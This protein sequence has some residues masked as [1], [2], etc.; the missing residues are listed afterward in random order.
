MDTQVL[1]VG[2]G[3]S[4]LVAARKLK[5]HGVSSLILDKGRSVGGRLATRRIQDGL[6][7]HGAQF[8]TA[9][10]QTFQDQIDKWI[11]EDLVYVWGHGWSDG[12]LK[13]TAGDGHPRYVTR[14]GMNAMAQRIARDLDGVHVNVQVRSVEYNEGLWV[15]TDTE[16]KVFTGMALL[17]TPP[18]PQ[19]L[20]LMQNVPLSDADRKT[21]ERIEYGPCLC[22]LHVI[23]GDVD[24]PD[25]GAIQV[26]D[27]AVYWVADNARKGISA[28]R[29]ITTHADARFSRQHYD[30][31]EEE[32][33]KLLREAF[34]E[35]LT[36]GSKIIEEQLKK[37]RYSVP[38]VTHPTETL[39]ADNLSLAFVGD[40]F[41]GRG[42]IEGAYLSGL[43]GAEALLDV[44]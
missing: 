22:G 36:P 7:D 1:I 17:M 15:L 38:L 29:I 20:A 9:R 13:R 44:L 35:R 32:T 24:L 25:P 34:E 10:T 12:S 41:G 23:D 18:A 30:A 31:P 2:A 28:Q 8:F 27:Q 16:E 4:G 37:W 5:E 11:A 26:P 19:S 14:G 21:L 33:L 3:I 43:A 42:R 40:A 39:L 6:A